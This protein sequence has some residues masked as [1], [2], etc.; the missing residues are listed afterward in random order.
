MTAA[1]TTGARRFAG[2]AL[3]ALL[4]LAM[5]A[6]C[7]R[8]TQSLAERA[9]QQETDFVGS[10]QAQGA[11]VQEKS[12]PPHGVGYVVNLSGATLTDDTF[13][14]LKGLKRLAELDLS[15]SSLTDAQMDQLN[16]VSN[17]LVRLDLSNT[18]ITDAGLEKLKRVY[19]LF[20]LNAAG[21]K[22]TPAG[23]ARFQKQRLE[24]PY[25][26]VNHTNV[27]LK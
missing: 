13:R 23:V 17:L 16:E 24:S 11:T 27:K 15:R 14:D 22:V 4:S 21:T 25:T 10:L 2:S 20:N 1:I 9:K 18:A 7:S 26:R 19:V 8:P 3:P 6:G 5:L 12:Y